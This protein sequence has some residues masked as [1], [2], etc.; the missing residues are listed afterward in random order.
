[1]FLLVDAKSSVYL[2]VIY[3]NHVGTLEHTATL[4][5][6]QMEKFPPDQMNT[7]GQKNELDD[8]FFLLFDSKLMEMWTIAT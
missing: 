6:V 2:S 8:F 4:N 5:F 3:V 7:S 1:M